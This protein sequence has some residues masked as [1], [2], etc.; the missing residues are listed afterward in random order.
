MKRL[1]HPLTLGML[2]IVWSAYAIHISAATDE[3][4]WFARSGTLWV[5]SGAALTVR[6]LLI[7]GPDKYHADLNTVDGGTAGITPQAEAENKES[8]LNT[9]SLH[10]GSWL[11]II[12]T[13]TCGYGDLIEKV[14]AK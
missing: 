7:L 11:V 5:L 12:G 1:I 13:F 9:T 2:C 10:V 8:R 4:H 14:V 6:S 3:W